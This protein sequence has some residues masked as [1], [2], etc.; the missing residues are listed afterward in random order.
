MV[1][2][3]ARF[4]L[5][6]ISNIRETRETVTRARA[7]T[8]TTSDMATIFDPPGSYRMLIGP[9]YNGMQ[10]RKNNAITLAF[11]TLLGWF[12]Q[13]KIKS[14]SPRRLPRRCCIVLVQF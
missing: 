4:T 8:T 10:T 1:H 5:H 12:I 6:A 2:S 13:R 3:H 14:I 9:E 11:L 7:Q